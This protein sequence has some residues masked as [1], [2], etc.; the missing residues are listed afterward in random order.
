MAKFPFHE[1]KPDAEGNVNVSIAYLNRLARTVAGLSDFAGQL[2]IFDGDGIYIRPGPK[3]PTGGTGFWAEITGHTSDGD[4]Q[5]TYSWEQV[6]KTS[7][8]YG[9]WTAVSPSVTGADNAFNT[10]EDMNAATGTQG[11]G[12]DADHLDTDEFTFT[13]Q[14]CPT[15]AIVRLHE[16]DVS[17]ETDSEYWF[18]YANGVDG[19]CD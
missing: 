5:W 11:N 2:S 14:P 13:I 12:V 16:V 9:E 18:V 6:E 15:G 7:T 1:L 10:L 19:E 17:G 4:N 3:G 8:G